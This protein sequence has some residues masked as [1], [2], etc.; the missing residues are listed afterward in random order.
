MTNS[1]DFGPWRPLY[2]RKGPM[3]RSLLRT[4]TNAGIAIMPARL[5]EPKSDAIMSDAHDYLRF[6][7]KLT[8][9]LA[10]LPDPQIET[11]GLA[12]PTALIGNFNSVR[13]VAGY[14]MDPMSTPM[15][16][17]SELT[18]SLN[19]ATGFLTERHR[20]IWTQ[21]HSLM[22]G[23]PLPAN[24]SVRKQASL[25]FPRLGESS[26][27]AKKAVI[28]SFFAN[29]QDYLSAFRAGDLRRLY[30]DHDVMLAYYLGVR[31]Q[32]DKVERT[33]NGYTTKSREVNDPLYART[34][35]KQGKRFDADK[36][37][38][39]NGTIV[40]GHFAGRRR[41]VYAAPAGPNYFLSSFFSMFR[42][43][44]LNR[45]E[46][47][48]KHRGAQHLEQKV[49]DF[50]F[51]LG[52]DVKQFDQSVSAWQLDFFVEQFT[53]MTDNW[54]FFL[55][56]FLSAPY[57]QPFPWLGPITPGYQPGYGDPFDLTTFTMNYGLPSGIA[58]NPDIGKYLMTATY[59]CVLDDVVGDLLEVG[60]DSTLR[61]LHPKV[62]LL[63]SSDDAVLLFKEEKHALKARELVSRNE[64]NYFRIE[65]EVG[66]SFLGSVGY[67]DERGRIKFTPN[68]TTFIS[69]WFWAEN[70]VYSKKREFSPIGW[71]A[72]QRHYAAAPMFSDVWEILAKTWR[73][74]YREDVDAREAAALSQLRF[75]LDYSTLSP[76][77]I[78]VL[79]NPDKLYYKID[80]A[81]VDPRLVE[82]EIASIP[83]EAFEHHIEPFF[84]RS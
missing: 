52:G 74:Q 83:F 80:P 65:P 34:S 27:A 69:N 28:M 22:F 68:I 26:P 46:F 4:T 78:E 23:S 38:R 77:D 59:L 12:G 49:A 53:N 84:K 11:T 13:T 29:A 37:V 31:V 21:L 70:G 15:M 47:T 19:L 76:E 40:P 79:L 6:V 7:D 35:G 10:A 44:Y 33:E 63:N 39:I 5:G 82:S 18:A 42:K 30:D 51:M 17:N 48:F 73:E 8:D 62:G 67:R 61:G 45:Y 57:Y 60:L 58:P 36:T 32:P 64:T 3:Q 9:R 43:H 56:K 50:G 2:D 72:R 14:V 24:L 71:F 41:S 20:M 75:K 55:R 54:R 66:I 81:D 16:D 25:G 1:V